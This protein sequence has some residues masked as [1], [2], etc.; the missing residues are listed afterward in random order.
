MSD[1]HE[2]GLKQKAEEAKK[3][4]GKGRNTNNTTL[5]GQECKL[6]YPDG[7]EFDCQIKSY[8][9]KSRFRVTFYERKKPN[10]NKEKSS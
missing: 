3:E 4:E 6:V 9:G 7:D 8:K 5:V 2:D 10:K 1:F